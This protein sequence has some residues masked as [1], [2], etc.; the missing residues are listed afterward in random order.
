MQKSAKIDRN[1]S[2]FCKDADLFKRKNFFLIYFQQLT[3]A[4]TLRKSFTNI[5]RSLPRPFRVYERLVGRIVLIRCSWID[6]RVI[7][8]SA[9]ASTRSTVDHDTV[10]LHHL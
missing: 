10:L 8:R 4:I 5:G 6:A 2:N 7:G 1:G 9:N 3:I